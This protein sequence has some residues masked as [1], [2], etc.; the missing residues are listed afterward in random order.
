MTSLQTT[1]RQHLRVTVYLAL[2]SSLETSV[3]M[4]IINKLKNFPLN[5]LLQ[6]SILVT[7]WLFCTHVQFLTHSLSLLSYDKFCCS[8]GHSW[9]FCKFNFMQRMEV[10]CEKWNQIFSGLLTNKNLL[11]CCLMKLNIQNLKELRKLP[12]LV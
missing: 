4:E 5:C 6:P 3:R 10:Y 11:L 9:R 1:I 7:L 2:V 8:Y 12:Q